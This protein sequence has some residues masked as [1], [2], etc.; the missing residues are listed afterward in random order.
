M[1][2]TPLHRCK[3]ILD[4]FP[5]GVPSDVFSTES[6]VAYWLAA[7]VSLH[8]RTPVIIDGQKM[9]MAKIVTGDVADPLVVEQLKAIHEYLVKAYADAER[10]FTPA[11]TI[12][13][14]AMKLVNFPFGNIKYR[15]GMNV[16]F[17][18]Q[19]QRDDDPRLTWRITPV[20]NGKEDCVLV[21]NDEAQAKYDLLTEKKAELDDI[22]KTLGIEWYEKQ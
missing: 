10:R 13:D 16:Q 20:Y 12:A 4:R 9:S 15:Y 5:Q 18:P 19:K 6:R 14:F 22:T 11:T 7:F 8:D 21:Y 1:A 2:T 17:T 3:E